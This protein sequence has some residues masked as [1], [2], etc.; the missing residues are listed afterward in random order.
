[1]KEQR[2]PMY[3]VRHM[4]IGDTPEDTFMRGKLCHTD[5]H[6]LEAADRFAQEVG[7]VLIPP[8]GNDSYMAEKLFE[9]LTWS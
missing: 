5:F 8:R 9:A 2:K 1:M 7:G 4:T 3:T 6:T